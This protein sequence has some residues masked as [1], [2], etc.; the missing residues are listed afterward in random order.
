MN[1]VS[2]FQPAEHSEEDLKVRFAGYLHE[3]PDNDLER[4]NAARLLFPLQ[5]QVGLAL[6]V[7]QNW[8][9]DPVVIAELD[10]LGNSGADA[11][12]PSKADVARRYMKIADDKAQT[13]DQRLKALDK[14]AELMGM[15]P[16]P[17]AGGFGGVSIDNRRVF[18][19][20]AA[21]A[22]DEWEGETVEQQAKLITGNVR[23][24]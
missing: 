4:M 3:R 10:R 22:I 23:A 9:N 6:D 11:N 14:Y 19:L 15:K 13:I 1:V 24:G 18:V 5:S 7:A 8:P 16:A 20:P 2:P 21:Q 12:L 17:G